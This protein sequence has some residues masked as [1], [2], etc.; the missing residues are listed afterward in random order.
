MH[1]YEVR[2][3]LEGFAAYVAANRADTEGLNALR[4]CMADLY[5]Y[6]AEDN[7]A[8]F[9][10]ADLAIHLQVAAMSG[11]PWLHKMVQSL[12]WSVKRLGQQSLMQPG[13]SRA[14]LGEHQA[15]L[16]S[17][18]DRDSSGARAHL[19]AHG[20]LAR[21]CAPHHGGSAARKRHHR[22]LSGFP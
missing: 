4:R 14:S 20:Q 10:D 2:T 8:G 21:L 12:T 15:L 19:Q 11:N 5:R 7:I 18:E 3:E 9:L 17:I 6:S 13:R 16:H 1:I 22:W